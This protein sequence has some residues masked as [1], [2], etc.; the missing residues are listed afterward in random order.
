M[1]FP[2]AR[3][4]F[5]KNP[6]HGVTTPEPALGWTTIPRFFFSFPTLAE[7]PDRCK[8]AIHELTALRARLA[9][10]RAAQS[11][12]LTRIDA[13]IESLARSAAASG[14]LVRRLSAL[15]HLHENNVRRDG[16]WLS[17]R[18]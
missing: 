4:I 15:V 18:S 10:D 13:I 1:A 7:T 12:A 17:L 5:G 14:A 9:T 16:L 8:T 2:W 3:P 6:S 11:D